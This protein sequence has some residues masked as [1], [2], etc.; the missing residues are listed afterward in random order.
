[1]EHVL[2]GGGYS[3]IGVRVGERPAARAQLFRCIPHDK[4]V[5]RKGKHFNVV[6]VITNGHDLLAGNAP[7]VGPAL[8]RVSLGT[9]GVEH[10]DN[11]KIA[12]RVLGAHHGDGQ[13][14]AFEDLQ[15]AL[16]VGDRA[17]EH[18]LHGIGGQR[19]L[20]RNHELDVL[21]VF[22]QPALDAGFQLVQ[23]LDHD[24]AG[25][26]A[27]KTV[28]VKSENG[29]TAKFLHH[30][31]EFAAGRLGEQ[32]AV[33]SFSGEGAGDGAIGTDQPEI[34]SKLLSD[35]QGEG[36]AASGDEDDLDALGVRVSEGCE[37]GFGNLEF[38]VEQGTVNIDGNEAERIGGHK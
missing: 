28:A 26:F 12:A 7:E 21:H 27:V 23:T 19:I 14:A 3:V 10:F 13:A 8:E 35:G 11:R 34:K 22:F 33:E 32:V 1:M 38:G 17:A 25:T 24:G 2:D 31:D 6:I 15:Y 20:D 18:G 36:V 9:A 30:V 16:H 4:W 5:A 37:L 29:L